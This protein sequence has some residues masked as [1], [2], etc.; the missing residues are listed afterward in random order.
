MGWRDQLQEA[1]FRDAS[2]F[3]AR[4][5]LSGGRKNVVFEFP[6]RDLPV[7]EDLGRRARSHRLE[8]YVLGPDYFSKRDQLIDALERPGPGT[9]I[10]PYRG[11]KFVSV[12]GF[13]EQETQEEGG[14]ATFSIEFIEADTRAAA[15]ISIAAPS[16]LYTASAGQMI[17]AAQDRFVGG[18]LTMLP[19]G[20]SV[21]GFSLK[22]VAK[23]LTDWTLTLKKA[24]SPVIHA[25]QTLSTMKAQLDAIVF[26]ADTLARTPIAIATQVGLIMQSLVDWPDTPRLGVTALMAAYGFHTTAIRPVATT[27]TRAIEQRNGD[28]LKAF[29]RTVSVTQ[30]GQFA[31]RAV[32]SPGRTISL[33]LRTTDLSAPLGYDSYEDAVAVRDLITDAIDTISESADDDTFSALMQIRADLAAGVPGDPNVLP[34]LTAFSP[35][36]TQPALVL[37]QRLYGSIGLVD[38]LVTRN[39]VAHPGFVPGSRPLQVLSHA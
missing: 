36:I 27:T 26:A 10:H 17:T 5:E 3:V 11:V 8:A 29:L 4:A 12:L 22:S 9:L 37:A 6:N 35:S 14:I 31:I 15:P 32:S 33:A 24:L 34:R 13:S 19:S 16:A 1:G 38:D 18:Y 7:I 30:A 21:P 39:H 25:T 23:I 28:E 2:F 20:L